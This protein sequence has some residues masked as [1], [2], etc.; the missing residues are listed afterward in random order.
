MGLATYSVVLACMGEVKESFRFADLAFKVLSKFNDKGL[1]GQVMMQVNSVVDVARHSLSECRRSL[2]D[3]YK[4]AIRSGHTDVTMFALHF[5]DEIGA[6]AGL[7]LR[8]QYEI[9][10]ENIARMSAYRVEYAMN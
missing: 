3:S 4:K 9:L 6:W 5:S 2:S 1:L 10:Q 7:P 8:A